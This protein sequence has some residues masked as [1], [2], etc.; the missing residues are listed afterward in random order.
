MFPKATEKH[1]IEIQ[2]GIPKVSKE[3]NLTIV[4]HNYPEG[5][6]MIVRNHIDHGTVILETKDGT[7]EFKVDYLKKYHGNPF[8]KQSRKIGGKGYDR[9]PKSN[10]E[11]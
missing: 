11:S 1:Y 9:K 2:G 7:R 5:E 6:G 8:E 10:S 4:E 3:G